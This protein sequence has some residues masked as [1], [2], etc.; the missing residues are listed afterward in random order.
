MSNIWQV[1]CAGNRADIAGE[2]SGAKEIDREKEDMQM[3]KGIVKGIV[4]GAVF[5]V[6]VVL[7]GFSMNH[8]N[9]DLTAEMKEAT[10][11]VVNFYYQDE[12]I[13]ELFGYVPL[14]LWIR[15][16]FFL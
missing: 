13:N 11:P 3:S 12:Q 9:E 5:I 16:V 4:L 1:V 15:N 10:L 8:T 6:A 14:R 7:F 2:N